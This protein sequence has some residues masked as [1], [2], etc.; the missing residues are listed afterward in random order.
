MLGEVS[1]CWNRYADGK[2]RFHDQTLV[3]MACDNKEQEVVKF[4]R[5]LALCHTVMVDGKEGDL[6]YQ[7]ASPDEEALVTAARNFGYVFVARTQDTITVNELGV[8]RTYNVLALMDFNSVRKRMSV[9]VRDPEEKIMLYTKGADD[10]IL[11][12]LYRGSKNYDVTEKALDSFASETLRT[13]CVACKHVEESVYI[14]W[15]KK[16]KEALVTL[17]DRAKELDATYE[18]IET[19]LELLGVTAIEDKLQDGVPETIELLAK[20]DIKVWM[21]T[22][23]KQETA[24]NIGFASR[25]L[26]DDMEILDGCKICEMMETALKN[27][28]TS[29]NVVLKRD[30]A[31][32]FRRTA[33]VVTGELLVSHC[34]L[35]FLKGIGL[36][37]QFEI[38]S[39]ILS[40]DAKKT[41]RKGAFLEKLEVLCCPKKSKKNNEETQK[42]R[43]FVELASR[44]QAVICCRVTP[45]QK[46][47]VVDMVKKHK[48][49]ITLAIGDGGNDVNMIKS[50]TPGFTSSPLS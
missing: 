3:D 14:V 19:N 28:S 18:E 38:H 25:L 12:R 22:G 34:C 23:D 44:C 35:Y 46:A 16:H 31:P 27:A 49:A 21:L 41:A 8:E 4:F 48:K 33:F 15:S 7:A 20:G 32:F 36:L 43:A 40:P 42:E 1:F 29:G 17:E 24:V 11:E 10:V 37:L 47:I 39:N 30:N 13:L 9:L 45:K 50:K 2:F 26:S 6:V 5:L